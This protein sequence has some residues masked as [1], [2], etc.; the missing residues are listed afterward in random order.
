MN[1][2]FNAGKKVAKISDDENKE[3]NIEDEKEEQQE[4]S[5]SNTS[6]NDNSD[7]KKQM[8]KVF[9]I[10]VGLFFIVLMLIIIISL[11]SGK[12]YT[13]DDV[14][15]EMKKA[16]IAYFNDHTNQLPKEGNISKIPLQNLIDAEYMKPIEKYLG[17]EATCDG[18]VSVERIDNTAVYSPHLDCGSDYKTVELY[19]KLTDGKNLVKEGY[20][21]YSMNSSYVYRGETVNNYIKLDNFLWR[22]VKIKSNGYT[23]LILADNSVLTTSW[24]DRYN[25]QTDY[26]SGI[27]NYATSRIK[28][29]IVSIYNGTYANEDQYEDTEYKFLSKSDKEKVVPVTICVGKRGDN[30]QSKNNSLECS[31]TMKKQY[32]TLLSVS[33][34]LNASSDNNCN[35]TI[36]KACSNYNYLKEKNTWWLLTGDKADSSR[37]YMVDT[38][39]GVVSKTCDI[40]SRIRPVI[41]LNNTVLYKSGNGTKDKPYKVK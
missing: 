40:Y 22:I 38:D 9:S 5:S 27:N 37:A 7:L 15:V 3:E 36:D 11:L 18:W 26:E 13:Y 24:D 21:L 1:I 10:I 30:D 4:E 41:T 25:K 39:G 31:A 23:Q 8:V 19:K 34:Y 17:D 2:D 14:E 12:K 6:R 32:I 29:L 16:A 35:S 28:E 20:G 33:D